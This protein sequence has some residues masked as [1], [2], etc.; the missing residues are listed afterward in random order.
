LTHLSNIENDSSIQDK[1]QKTQHI[2]DTLKHYQSSM[3]SFVPVPAIQSWLLAQERISEKDQYLCSM[4]IEPH[5]SSNTPPVA[6]IPDAIKDKLLKYS[7]K[8][9]KSEWPR[10]L[11]KSIESKFPFSEK[12]SP[13][14][15]RVSGSKSVDLTP[16]HS[17]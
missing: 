11:K 13:K 10:T 7:G 8:H 16:R 4:F 3:Y 17:G 2:I 5:S 1:D 12:K 15:V 6:L 14:L 9:A